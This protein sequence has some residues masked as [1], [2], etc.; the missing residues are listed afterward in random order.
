MNEASSIVFFIL[1][2]GGLIGIVEASGALTAGLTAAA[3]K[4]KGRE[5]L[6]IP[7]LMLLFSLGGAV[8]GMSEET[9]AFVPL[10]IGLGVAMGYDRVVGISISF[11]GGFSRLRWSIHES[12]HDRSR[13]ISS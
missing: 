7:V 10:M 12:I 8:F 3:L 1:V 4:M 5:K 11:V 13:A 9:L 6:F 2:I